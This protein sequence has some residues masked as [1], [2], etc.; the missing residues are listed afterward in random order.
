MRHRF[1]LATRPIWVTLGILLT[2]LLLAII[3]NWF[4]GRPRTAGQ[5]TAETAASPSRTAVEALSPSKWAGRAQDASDAGFRA[6][7][8]AAVE[9]RPAKPPTV[10]GAPL[11]LVAVGRPSL[12][13]CPSPCSVV[14]GTL[15]P[16]RR[17]VATSYGI[18]DGYLWRPL[19][20]GGRL[21]PTAMVVAHRSLPCGTQ[22]TFRF[23]G[24]VV[25]AVVRDR[26]PY[27]AGRTWDLGPAV[28]KALRFDGLDWVEWRLVR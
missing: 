2:G 11:A 20:C 19:A 16:W 1:W 17:A 26:G 13:V 3:A 22:V 10:T 7:Y 15:E 28:A 9:E 5:T 21:T 23:R 8:Q 24:H 4:V 12:T 6:T 25:E 27:V 14:I 18:R